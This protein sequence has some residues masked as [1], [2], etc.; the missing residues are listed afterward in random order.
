MA[1]PEFVLKLREKIGHDLLWMPCVT[2]VVFDVDDRVLLTR[3]VHDDRWA[4]VGG[5]LDPGEQPAVGIQREILE[6]TGVEAVVESL[7]S[8]Y[9]L[10]PGSYPNGD[11][12]QYL[13]L[14]FRCTSVAGHARVNDDENTDV[15]WF[16]QLDLP[17]SVIEP[18]R[19]LVAQARKRDPIP[20]YVVTP[21]L[22]R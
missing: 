17:S 2:A 19:Q 8:V 4:L 9:S 6:E 12:V 15:G 3:R 5:I 21:P 7:V 10:P 11:Q 13:D 1:T 18:D 16:A 22:V 14:C 20:V